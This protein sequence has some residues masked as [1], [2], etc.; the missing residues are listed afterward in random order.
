MIAQD[1]VAFFG[2]RYPDRIALTDGDRGTDTTW[3][4]LDDRVGRLA[5]GLTAGLGLCRGDRV[6]VLA[7]PHPDVFA[8][9]FAC[10]R[11][12]LIFTPLNWRLAAPELSYI[13]TDAGAAVMVHDDAWRALAMETAGTAGIKRCV[14]GGSLDG[15]PMA[16][17]LDN[18]LD[19]VCQILY[20]S[21]T[22]G[23][24]KGAIGTFGTL[25][26]NMMNSSQPKGLT[27]PG[28]H[29]YN[30][31]PLFH[32]GGLNSTANPVL[33]NGG[34]VTTAARFDPAAALRAI[35]DPDQ[36]ITHVAL[37]P[38]MY[39]AIADQPGFADAD[40]SN[41]RV[42]VVAGGLAPVPLIRIYEEHGVLLEAHYGG[43]EMGPSV[44]ALAPHERSLLEAGSVGK[45][46][47]HT[48]VR[49]VD[50]EGRDV[51]AGEEGEV[52]IK[53]PSVTPGYW[54]RDSAEFFTDGW[55]RT[56]DVARRDDDGFYFL[57][58]RV[59]DMYKSGGENVY[60]AEVE[61]L[62]LEHPAV[63][64]VAVIGVPDAKWGEVGLALVVAA[65]DAEVTLETL[66]DVIAGRL[67]R[68]KYPKRVLVVDEL[69]RNV[70]GK[71]S[72]VDLRK[73]Y[74]GSSVA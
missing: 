57:V 73:Q 66:H 51:D 18:S 26:W 58:D 23:F 49:L 40:L 42:A 27:A 34:R 21:G 22:T 74:S 4:A 54:G 68:Y 65:P 64:E 59:K 11:A 41:I 56:G 62:L 63:A 1:W 2:D 35:T 8:L 70:T 60:P 71:V 31:L 36:A 9:Q 20:T 38:V 13:C 43:T 45:P 12:G 67:A 37:V 17:T 61:R 19:D 72:K 52:W 69:A 16:P 47:Q 5:T 50:D 25:L 28:V 14:E 53:G 10:F 6:A 39:Q 44:L 55:F 32:A 46:V 15:D 48:A 3:R 30:P 29:V 7:D 33:L 24:P